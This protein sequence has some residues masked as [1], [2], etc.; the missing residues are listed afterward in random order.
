MFQVSRSLYRRLAPHAVGDTRQVIERNRIRILDACER[1][2]RRMEAEPDFADPARYLFE[3]V[4]VCLPVSG[5]GW[6]RRLIDFHVAA[7]QRLIAEMPRERQC[8]A[9]T[10]QGTPCEREPV[11]GGEFCPSHR[12]LEHIRETPEP[13]S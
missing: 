2:L 3:E 4:R 9:F 8:A 6:A 10:R 11:E 7:A 1:T 5:Q 13:I 12:H